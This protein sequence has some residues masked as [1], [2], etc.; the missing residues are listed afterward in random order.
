M[1]QRSRRK[2]S[3]VVAGEDPADA[4]PETN[5]GGHILTDPE[6]HKGIL[7]GKEVGMVGQQVERLLKPAT[8]QGEGLMATEGGRSLELHTWPCLCA[9]SNEQ[10]G[11]YHS[12]EVGTASAD[13][14][15]RVLAQRCACGMQDSTSHPSAAAVE[16]I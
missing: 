5:R 10:P 2:V 13:S 6:Q 7:T 3:G 1:A 12:R 11:L 14:S 16:E 4:A 15:A 8:A 9:E